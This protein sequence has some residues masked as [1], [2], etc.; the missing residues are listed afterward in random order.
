MNRE[1]CFR[2]IPQRKCLGDYSES[3]FFSR[4]RRCSRVMKTN[5]ETNLWLSLSRRVQHFPFFSLFPVLSARK[6]RRNRE[7]D[8][9]RASRQPSVADRTSAKKYR[10]VAIRDATSWT[11]DRAM[12]W[13]IYYSRITPTRRAIIFI[14]IMTGEQLN[15]HGKSHGS[16]NEPRP[17]IRR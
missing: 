10:G 4:L 6:E 5:R 8:F 9:H 3:S 12:R 1:I 15:L 16:R 2:N 14:S 13:L 11:S 7:S 17:R